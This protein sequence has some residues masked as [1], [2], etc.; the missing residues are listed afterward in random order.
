MIRYSEQKINNDDIEMVKSSLSSP[1]LTQGPEIE[2]FEN[3][4]SEICCCKD[5]IAVS[6]ATAGLHLAYL[7]VGLKSDDIV[8]TVGNTFVATASAAK[9]CGAAVEFVDINLETYNIC[10]HALERKLLA[11]KRMPSVLCVVHFAGRPAPMKRISEIC[12]KYSI[13]VIEDASH[14][15]GAKF[16]NKAIG[17]CQYSEAVIFSFHPVKIITS[18]EGGMICTNNEEIAKRIRSLR[19]HGI[20]RDGTIPWYPDQ[21]E[22]G[23]NYRMT[24]LQAAL[25]RSQLTKLQSFFDHRTDLANYYDEALSDLS[26]T[27][28]QKDNDLYV[29]A[30]HLYVI[31]LNGRSEVDR[32]NFIKFL[33]DKQIGA[34]LHYY[35]VYKF[36]FF[37]EDSCD[38]PCN[39]QY[40]STAVTIPLST[41]LTR[42]NQ[43]YIIEKIKV[44]LGE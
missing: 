35:P 37:R 4:I 8:W 1:F 44:F 40:F 18:G 20:V 34:N 11:A 6:N 24:E 23:Y 21:L 5:S 31:L 28:P 3:A 17:S 36:D 39:E 41:K 38:F 25:G 32:N 30:K 43:K 22:I 42:K 19:S 10:E 9:Y 14:A 13:K 33:H 26:V 27:T 7:A 12:Q 16:K 2:K 15:L 29:S